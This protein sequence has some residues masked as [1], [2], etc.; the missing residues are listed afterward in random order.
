MG[1][2]VRARL[3]PKIAR[4]DWEPGSANG[5]E[6][7]KRASDGNRGSEA[8]VELYLGTSSEYR[9]R[10]IERPESRDA[11]G[12]DTRLTSVAGGGG[13]GGGGG[14]SRSDLWWS[15]VGSAAVSVLWS[16]WCGGASG[17]VVAGSSPR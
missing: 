7:G 11:R 6:D 12:S 3:S 8:G 9:G 15:A 10:T 14:G 16:E 5:G 13:G 17:S 4:F 2:V 1:S